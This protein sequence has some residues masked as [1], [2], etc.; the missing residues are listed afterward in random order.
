MDIHSLFIIYKLMNTNANNL[1]NASTVVKTFLLNS[2]SNTTKVVNIKLII[3]MKTIINITNRMKINGIGIRTIEIW[4]KI[5]R[6]WF[7][8]LHKNQNIKRKV[9]QRSRLIRWNRHYI[10]NKD[11]WTRFNRKHRKNKMIRHNRNNKKI[12]PIYLI[13]RCVLSVIYSFYRMIQFYN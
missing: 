4:V 9:C 11:L 2:Y 7:N 3:K 6:K 12:N 5:R 13:I 8:N 1:P 10:K